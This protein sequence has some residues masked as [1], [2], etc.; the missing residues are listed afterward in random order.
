MIE[1]GL[2][3]YIIIFMIVAALV[4]ASCFIPIYGFLRK[5]WKG[6]AIG[7]LLQ[8]IICAVV[9]ALIVLG[10]Y[11]YQKREIRQY[12][13]NAMVTV[14]KYDGD[15]NALTWY[16]KA[17]EECF[18]EKKK[19]DGELTLVAD[20]N[21]KLFDVIPLDSFGVCVDDVVTV[22]FD[23]GRHKV[24]A[25]EYDQPLEVVSV[26]WDKVKEYFENHP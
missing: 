25:T 2:L 9:C 18:F 1:Q 15:D 6:L 22:R 24:T 8:P 21:A 7:C 10:V 5:R 14:R 17:D 4:A 11:F 19:K 26:D 16:L 3:F 20:G 13:E 23:Q 12:R